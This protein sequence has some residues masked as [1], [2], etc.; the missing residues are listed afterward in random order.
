[1][2]TPEESNKEHSTNKIVRLN[3]ENVDWSDADLYI[4]AETFLDHT[5]IDELESDK[6]LENYK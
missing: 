6:I 5:E 4:P 3:S 2:S 1:M